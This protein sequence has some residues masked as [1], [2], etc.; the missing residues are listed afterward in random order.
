VIRVEKLKV[1]YEKANIM[2]LRDIML[3]IHENMIL[4]ILG[5]NG[6]GKT[7]LLKSIAGILP[8]QGYVYVDGIEVSKA[9][10]RVL[11]RLISYMGDVV[12]PEALSLTV[13][14][15]LLTA[16]YHILRKFFE[17]RQDIEIVDET[18]KKLG[19]SHLK[20]RRLSQLSSGELRIVIIAMALVKN[21]KYI[22][23]DEPDAHLDLKNKIMVSRLIK[24]FSR[25]KVVVFTTHDV[26]FAINTSTHIA[27]LKNG[28][29]I[30]VGDVKDVIEK[31]YL[32]KAFD[33]KFKLLRDRELPV[34]VPVY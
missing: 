20:N 13:F 12:V 28:K 14:E 8:Y 15:A 31:N 4:G 34:P 24:Q 33:V 19:I 18:L 16:R 27:L 7:T 3:D 26:Y 6:A 30:Y 17:T 29:L 23:L 2:A 9:P 22:L 1:V 25:D 5:P 10:L 32:E 11:S 21:T